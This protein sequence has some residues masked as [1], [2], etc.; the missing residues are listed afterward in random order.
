[1]RVPKKV[2][3]SFLHFL[4]LDSNQWLKSKLYHQIQIQ[5]SQNSTRPKKTRKGLIHHEKFQPNISPNPNPIFSQYSGVFYLC[6]ENPRGLT[7]SLFSKYACYNSAS[8]MSQ[9]TIYL[10][11]YHNTLYIHQKK[12]WAFREAEDSKESLMK[13]TEI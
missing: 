1:M 2:S 6:S 7:D 5:R 9:F 3:D 13:L 11:A 4:D 12:Q 10:Y 8:W